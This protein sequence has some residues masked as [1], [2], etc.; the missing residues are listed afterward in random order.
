MYYVSHMMTLTRDTKG[1]GR[2]PESP[3][4]LWALQTRRTCSVTERAAAQSHSVLIRGCQN[5]LHWDMPRASFSLWRQLRRKNYTTTI[6]PPFVLARDDPFM[7]WG[8]GTPYR[9]TVTPWVSVHVYD[10]YHIFFW[11]TPVRTFEV[12]PVT[13]CSQKKTGGWFCS[14]CLP[15]LLAL[16]LCCRC[17]H[18]CCL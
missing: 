10:G 15:G 4:V 13:G 14:F 3:V 17:M 8:F 5:L 16:L 6:R 11:H 1:T 18:H 7:L 2:E 9:D 12:Q